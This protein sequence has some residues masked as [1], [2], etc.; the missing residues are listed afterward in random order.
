MISGDDFGEKCIFLDGFRQQDTFWGSKPD[1][2]LSNL[3]FTGFKMISRAISSI[4][5]GLEG[6]DPSIYIRFFDFSIPKSNVEI[7]DEF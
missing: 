3:D 2:R 6:L 4:W 1:F 5:R 7:F